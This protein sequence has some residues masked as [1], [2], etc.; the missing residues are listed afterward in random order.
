M[1]GIN[2]VLL[3][4]DASAAS[5]NAAHVARK[6][7]SLESADLHVVLAHVLR[8]AAGEV[9][10]AL[11]NDDR[12]RLATLQADIG[13][14]VTVA[15]EYG[16]SAARTIVSYARS[17]LIDLIA[18]GTHGRGSFARFFV[19]SVA[20]EVL[21]TAHTPVIVAGPE[22]QPATSGFGCV[23]AAVDF[24]DASKEVL[25]YAATIAYRCN[26]RLVAVHVIDNTRVPGYAQVQAAQ[27]RDDQALAE[28]NSFVKAA[29]LQTEADT[30]IKV[31]AVHDQIVATGR[32]Y[33]AELI[34][35]GSSGQGA[36]GYRL[37]G[38]VADRVVRTSDAPV[39]VH[40]HAD[41]HK[42]LDA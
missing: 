13:D 22:A 25:R 16:Y 34:C 5:D 24:S 38:S 3:A 30:H 28:L 32:E 6:I 15:L 33:N 18:I 39:L 12:N 1:N 26:A 35:T 20:A 29:D 8:G 31:G 7:A 2:R 23:L 42:V 37:L 21:R 17:H 4:T 9:D 27:N 10:Q 14:R 41:A 36:L 40:R 11:L 19:G